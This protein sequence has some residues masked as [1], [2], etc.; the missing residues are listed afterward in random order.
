MGQILKLDFDGTDLYESVKDEPDRSDYYMSFINDFDY[1]D[2]ILDGLTPEDLF[3]VGKDYFEG[4]NG[5]DWDQD[6]AKKYYQAAAEKGCIEAMIELAFQYKHAL[7]PHYT[8]AMHWF[9]K[10]AEKC[11]VSCSLSFRKLC[12]EASRDSCKA[13]S[14]AVETACAE[15]KYRI[16]QMY[17]EG[18]GVEQ[19]YKQAAFWYE[20]AGKCDANYEIEIDGKKIHNWKNK[21]LCKAGTIYYDGEEGVPKSRVKA[22]ECFREAVNNGDKN[23]V[24]NYFLGL[25]CLKGENI[26]KD[27][28][29]AR[30]CFENAVSQGHAASLGCL[31]YMYETGKAKI[32]GA[33]LPERLAETPSF[34]EAA[35]RLGYVFTR[36]DDFV[37]EINEMRNDYQKRIYSALPK[38]S[39]LYKVFIGEEDG[40]DRGIFWFEAAAETNHDD[41]LFRLILLYN[42]NREDGIHKQPNAERIAYFIN[43]IYPLDEEIKKTVFNK[44]DCKCFIDKFLKLALFSRREGLLALGDDTEE[45]NYFI[46]TGLTLIGN[47]IHINITKVIL[48]FLLDIGSREGADMAA[49]KIIL[50]GVCGIGAVDNIHDF[51]M[52]LYDACGEDNTLEDDINDNDAE[53]DNPW[54]Y[55]KTAH[56]HYH[57]EEWDNAI[58]GFQK[59]IDLAADEDDRRNFNYLLISVC[60]DKQNAQSFEERISPYEQMIDKLK[61]VKT[62]SFADFFG[63][64]RAGDY[65]DFAAALALFEE[66]DLLKRL[67][68]EAVKSPLLTHDFP[69]L[70]NYVSPQFSHWGPTPLY[71]ITT[72][73]SWKKMKDPGKML[74]F[75]IDNGADVNAA[76]ADKSTPL[77][78][79]TCNAFEPTEVLKA[80]LELGAD[81]DKSGLFGD[82]EFTPLIQSLSPVYDEDENASYPLNETSIEQASLLLEH[83]ADPN[84]ACPSFPDYPPLSMA[85]IYGFKTENAP[86]GKAAPGILEF[87]E[88][89]IKKGAN[90]NFLDSD[91]DTPL[92]IAKEENLPLAE[93]I[94][95]KY[96]ALMP[97]ELEAA[98]DDGRHDA[99]S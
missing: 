69:F 14:R 75:L 17:E 16:A 1:S 30:S 24:S 29:K 58:E 23:E 36:R 83:G 6:T 71:S 67:I 27:Y 43:K 57:N 18:E 3:R 96:G 53:T 10:A 97:D 54:F 55:Y 73:N 4:D 49:R 11:S 93:E 15:A 32:S 52:K 65:I 21:G 80:L 74:K 79:Q 2:L 91:N 22:I 26:E 61:G 95:L 51:M 81:P 47:G 78:N 72:K 25:E 56:L 76:A 40:Y 92:S 63:F 87:I 66:Y 9:K 68:A 38:E 20:E 44:K 28:E 50:Q 48:E 39:L 12:S 85:L 37:Y 88:L 60:Q 19:D 99:W 82:I 42:N 62:D 86:E 90:V 7:Y 13:V 46:K 98:D 64:K 34:G 8:K 89:L 45:E 84:L 41:A 5:R 77:L 31:D 94:L 70:N 59:A 35:E 33:G